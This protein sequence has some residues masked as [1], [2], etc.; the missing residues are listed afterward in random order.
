MPVIEMQAHIQER[1][2]Y[3][4]AIACFFRS[5]YQ[6]IFSSTPAPV[7]LYRGTAMRTY[8]TDSPEAAA[9]IL[10][11]VM[12]A[13]GHLDRHEL[14]LLDRHQIDRQLGLSRGQLHTVTRELCEDLLADMRVAW[15]D[16]CHVEPR[17][18]RALLAE[19][20]DPALRQKL[21]RLCFLLIGADGHIAEGESTVLLTA[22]DV[23]TAPGRRVGP[24]AAQRVS[25]CA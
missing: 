22:I 12:I 16:L 4:S 25:T 11:L 24:A 20:Q 21:L 5:M 7:R 9:R 14:E 10:A 3:R 17:I 13:D 6:P 2:K 15:G 23:W 1:P 8:A 18:L 19:V